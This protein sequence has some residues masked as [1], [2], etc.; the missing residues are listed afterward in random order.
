[1]QSSG[2]DSCNQVAPLR[3]IGQ[4]MAKLSI[5]DI[6][7]IKTV[8]ETPWSHPFIE[9]VIGTIRR[10]YLDDTLFWGAKDLQR[11]LD[12]FGTYYG[13]ARVYSSISGKTPRGLSGKSAVG[14]INIQDYAWKSY[15]NGRFSIPISA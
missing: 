10:G 3:A 13:E 15:C 9:R 11:K 4:W 8:P 2:I 6:D 5:L 14:K 12:E 1:M 7:E